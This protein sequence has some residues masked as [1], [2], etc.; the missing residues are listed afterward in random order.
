[1]QNPVFAWVLI[2]VGVLVL[3]ISAFAFPL[4]LR[5]PGF[6][7]K[8]TLGVVVGALIIVAALYTMAGTVV[9]PITSPAPGST[10]TSTPVTFT[11]GHTS[12][13]VQHFLWVG[14]SPGG[15]DLWNQDLGTGHSAV[16]SGL[17]TSGTIH[18]RYTTVSRAGYKYTD[19][20]Y[21][22]A[23][24]VA[25]PITSPAPGSTL[26]STPVTFTG[27]HTSAD[28]QHFLWVGTSP[29]GFDLWNQDLGTGHSAVVSGLPTSGTIHVRYTTVSSA[30]YK[31]T[32]QQYTMAVTVAPPI[33]SP[34]PG[35]TL[36]RTP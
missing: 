29:G 9:P 28:V 34:A 31:Y 15:F 22:M 32:D 14:T 19:Q 3:L 21:T 26:T 12:A 2:G 1:M 18:V 30:G 36:K 35:S 25:P 17:P 27:G 33:P 8:R 11:G 24:T 16:V 23:V 13:D 6:G 7:W 4:G 5:H 20:Q 10:L